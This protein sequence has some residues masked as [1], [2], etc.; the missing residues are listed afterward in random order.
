M[1]PAVMADT[2]ETQY[3]RFLDIGLFSRFLS[4]TKPYKGWITLALLL[5][6]L[7]TLAQMAQ[8]LL[9]KEAVDQNLLSGELD[10]FGTLALYF[11][12]LVGVQFF[13]GYLQ[14]LINALLGQRVVRDI[15]QDLFAKLTTMDAQYFATHAS[16]R[17]TNRITNDTEAVSNMVSS[18]LVNLIGDVLLLIGIAI[19][20]VLLSPKLSLISLICMPIILYGTILITRKMRIVQRKGR[21]IQ[22]NMAGHLTEQVEGQEVLR[23]FHC[24]SRNRAV[25]DKM[26][27]DYYQTVLKSNFLEAFQFSFIETASVIV[28]A[29]LFWYGAGL[30]A[31][32]GVTI[33]VM[34]AF[35]DYLRRIFFPI[36]DLSG[37]YTTMQAAMT[38]L[39][40]IFHLLDTPAAIHSP[41]QPQESG[42]TQGKIHFKNLYFDYGKGPVLRGINCHIAA[43]ERV[44]VVGPT[45]AGKS[46]LI[47]LLNR[48]Y[49]PKQGT[50]EIDGISVDRYP[51]ERLRQMVGMVQQETFL[52]AGTLLENIRLHHTHISREEAIQAARETGAAL[53]IEKLPGGYD[54][55]L[56]ERGANLSA[57]ERQL[58]GITRVFAFKPKILVMDEATSSVD[59]ISE[60]LIQDALERLLKGRTAL[61]IAHRLSTILHADRILVFA[62]GTIVEEGDHASLMA[63]GGLYAKLYDLQ[64]QQQN[65]ESHQTTA[66]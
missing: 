47:K 36:R 60:G 55:L 66:A 6:P 27:W 35:I 37:K 17:L 54:A 9:I 1:M 34:V 43:G 15:R 29:L 38:A 41:E 58:L 62:H 65:Q 32:D 11:A 40:R 64:F 2:E 30:S 31:D 42:V 5:L 3:G 7:T 50:L 33:G 14:S 59:T 20:M 63:K 57:G 16:G 56:T 45:G 53:F 22:A 61:I 48:T 24:Q 46:S 51:L 13:T 19:S 52:F 8:P 4:Y 18:G 26:N 10:G 12:G 39:E 28:V 25:F 23:L 44:A 49:D 21:V